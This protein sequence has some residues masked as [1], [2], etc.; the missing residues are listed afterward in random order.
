MLKKLLVAI[1]GTEYSWRALEYAMALAKMNDA[2]MVVLTVA[3]EGLT[4]TPQLP[5]ESELAGNV[6]EPAMQVGNDVLGAAKHL[7]DQP[8]STYRAPTRWLSAAA[9]RRKLLNAALRSAAIPSCL[10]RAASAR[11][12]G[13]LKTVSARPSSK[14]PPCL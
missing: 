3:K 5:L 4:H 1:D 7:I 14:T 2:E 10:V 11:L 6:N 9:L 12:K 8:S 13:C